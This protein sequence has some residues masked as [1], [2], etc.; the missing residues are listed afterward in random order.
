MR[1]GLCLTVVVH[2]INVHQQCKVESVALL[3]KFTIKC[4][5]GDQSSDKANLFLFLLPCLY[6]FVGN[7]ETTY[8]N[9]NIFCR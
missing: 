3:M 5:D 7:L 9:M 4:F 6:Q 8:A 1:T 2:K